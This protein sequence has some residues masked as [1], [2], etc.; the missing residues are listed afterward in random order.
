MATP[1][2][3]RAAEETYIK[4]K[5]LIEC[6]GWREF[7][8]PQIEKMMNDRKC[9]ALLDP[10]I[11][12]DQIHFQRGGY[13]ALNELLQHIETHQKFSSGMIAREELKVHSP[14]R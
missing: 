10:E 9:A 5:S 7:L 8:L 13:S 12:S 6:P 14:G 11:T 3:Y 1:A 4:I 2:Q